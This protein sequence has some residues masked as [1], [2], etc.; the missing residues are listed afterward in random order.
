[1]IK[2]TSRPLPRDLLFDPFIEKSNYKLFF[3][4]VLIL[5]AV[6]CSVHLFV[7]HCS[8]IVK[9]EDHLLTIALPLT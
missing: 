1:M 6:S 4:S 5:V 9:D 7:P 2:K 8:L 3:L